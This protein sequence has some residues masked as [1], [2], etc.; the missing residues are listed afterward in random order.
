MT[1]NEALAR[2]KVTNN[3][4]VVAQANV[5]EARRVFGVEDKKLCDARAE[6]SEALKNYWSALSNQLEKEGV[7]ELQ[8]AW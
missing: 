4:L 6:H 8:H 3:S 2:L 7:G 1:V 5:D